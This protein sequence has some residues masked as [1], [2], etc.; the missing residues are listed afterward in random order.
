MFKVIYTTTELAAYV[1]SSSAPLKAIGSLAGHSLRIQNYTRYGVSVYMSQE[2]I[3][4]IAPY[5]Y[6]IIENDASYYL[7]LDQFP[8]SDFVHQLSNITVRS[9]EEK[10]PYEMGIL[11]Q[12]VVS[13]PGDT[14][15]VSGD[16]TIT[17]TP[18][19]TI[20][21]TP[22]VSIAGTPAVSI[23]GT[24]NAAITSG[25]VNANIQ[26]A[27]I[28]AEVVNTASS[29]VPTITQANYGTG[30][31]GFYAPTA[32]T[33]V[34]NPMT[35]GTGFTLYSG[36]AATI[37]GSGFT[38]GAAG[39][40]VYTL[41]LGTDTVRLMHVDMNIVAAGQGI[42]IAERP[43]LS[44]NRL[45]IIVDLDSITIVRICNLAN[46]T[47][48]TILTDD[49]AITTFTALASGSLVTLGVF[50]DLAT[51]TIVANLYTG[52]LGGTL[53]ASCVTVDRSAYL[54][55]TPAAGANASVPT[56]GF[57]ADGA[58]TVIK[59]MFIKDPLAAIANSSASPDVR[60]YLSV[61]IPA[62]VYVR[63][64]NP[65]NYTAWFISGSCDIRGVVRP[66]YG[67]P[68]ITSPAQITLFGKLYTISKG[69]DGGQAG[70]AAN[71]SSVW[72][73][74]PAGTPATYFCAG[75]GGGGHGGGGNGASYGGGAGGSA[76][77]LGGQSGSGSN[78]YSGNAATYG[79]SP[80]VFADANLYGS[81]AAGAT[82]AG[83]NGRYTPQH[84]IAAFIIACATAINVQG[85]IA[86]T[87]PNGGVAGI[88][89]SSGKHGGMGGGGGGGSITLY[90]E[91]KVNVTGSININGGN[92]RSGVYGM[93]VA[94]DPTWNGNG[95]NGGIGSISMVQY[96]GAISG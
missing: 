11:I 38:F 82:F 75:N 26:N 49:I 62:D 90:T 87:G 86:A 66:A 84:G 33:L 68:G 91:D 40:Y 92:A 67:T 20:T 60:S 48:S 32:T 3:D 74:G 9:I 89:T 17:N 77:G 85:V 57:F 56:F 83:T 24:V 58:G 8:S 53:I 45:K 64:N 47:S 1:G 88:G 37:N 78:I 55:R 28:N 96:G 81:S 54:V 41:G 21:G 27:S 93:N 70:A 95:Y 13:A 16:M 59:N 2:K 31:D 10:K 4:Y 18:E 35:S 30:A 94:P 50:L 46:S 43:S 29:P 63:W 23:S 52:G 65:A 79:Y 61:T 51:G 80:L 22:A 6:L 76:S 36:T 7:Q 12:T 34:N 5:Q 44:D 73:A 42:F 15:N 71:S 39:A 19:V 69:G 25:T 14:I 72:T